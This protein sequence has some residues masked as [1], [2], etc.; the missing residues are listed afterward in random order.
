MARLVTLTLVVSLAGTGCSLKLEDRFAPSLQ[1]AVERDLH[2]DEAAERT[3][4]VDL[5]LR[6]RFESTFIR[7]DAEGELA[8]TVDV[9]IDGVDLDVEGD[10]RG[11]GWGYRGRVSLMPGIVFPGSTFVAAVI[12]VEYS[13]LEIDLQPLGDSGADVRGDLDLGRLGIPLG[14]HVETT[15]DEA[16]TPFLEWT[17]IPSVAEY[18][19]AQV[20]FDWAHALGLRASLGALLDLESDPW[21]EAGWRWTQSV[22]TAVV[23]EYE[24][25]LSGPYLGAGIRL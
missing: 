3:D 6:T 19:P 18:E 21:V 14:V 1:V 25:A 20:G 24:I 17:W 12:G 2:L 4:D 23:F 13:R 5:R 10:V 22:S 11:T 15:F 8:S 7:F 9:E 16:F